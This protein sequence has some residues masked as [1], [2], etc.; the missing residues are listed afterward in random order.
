MS[1]RWD[2][3]VSGE[4][5]MP[6]NDTLGFV[7]Q[8]SGDPAESVTITWEVPKGYLNSAGSAQGGM[9]AAFADA[10]M[11]AACAPHLDP[12]TYPALAEMKISIMRPAP[13]GTELVG[14]GYVVKKG[15][16]VLFVEAE[17]TDRDGTLI[18]R[19]SGTEIPAQ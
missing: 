8:R 1:T 3:I 17:I 2:A 12:D 14:R 6:V 4:I 9:L 11:G 7:L 13:A 18:A 16:R 5:T 19:A 10:L 15:S